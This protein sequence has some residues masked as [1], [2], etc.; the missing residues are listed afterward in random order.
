M[1]LSGDVNSA[2]GMIAMNEKMIM[3]VAMDGRGVLSRRGFLRSIGLGA[4]GASALTFTDL[5]ALQAGEL[6]K[7]QMA[8]IL[9]W[10]GGGPSQ[11]ETFDPKPGHANGGETKAIDTA[12]PGIR[13]ASAWEHTAKVMDDVTIVRSMTNREGNHQRA[14]Y[15]LHTG[16]APSGSVKHPSFGS[17]TAAELGDPKFDLPHIVSI[18]GPTIGAGML[19]VAFEPFIVQNPQQA[20][21]NVQL[22]V[23]AQ[24][25]ARR[26]GLLHSLELAGFANDGGGDRVKEHGALYRQTAGMVLSPRMKAFD[27]DA[28]NSATRDAYG[29]TAFGQ[30]CLLARR[31]VD[32]G[33]TFVEVRSNGWD[34]H[35]NNFERVG[36]LAGQVD[37]GFAALVSDLKQRGMLEHTL[38]VWMGEFGRTPKINPGGGRD[39]F[40]RAFNIALAGGGVKGGQVVG[41]SSADGTAVKDRPI[42]VTDLM[43]SFCHA[44]KIDPTKEN[45]SPLGRPIKIVDGGKIVKELFT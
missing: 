44:L 22:P 16:Y 28:E 25:F 43:T 1:S 34:T 11:F 5:M 12:V 18:G 26:L 15:Q 17:V 19:G 3:N 40:P 8:M 20:P 38:V 24:R 35:Q 36:T 29:R 41:A 13:I 2:E 39:H 10:M 33:V 23:P 31:L 37:P 6:R 4:A 45:M 9:L 14:T 32:A 21:T 30:G 27:I 7:R 42:A